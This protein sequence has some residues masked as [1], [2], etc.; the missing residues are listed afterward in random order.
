LLAPCGMLM[1]GAMVLISLLP[2]N[3][4]L[5]IGGI[6]FGMGLGAGWPMYLALVGDL[7]A[8][9]L[10]PKGTATALFLYDIGFFITPLAVGYFVPRFGTMGTFA[11]LAALAGCALVLLELFYWLPKQKDK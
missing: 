9:M 10:R 11:G 8:P 5:V 6:L 1:A 4:A 2:T 7:L 3:N